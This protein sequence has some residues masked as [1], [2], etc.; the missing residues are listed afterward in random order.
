[1][2]DREPVAAANFTLSLTSSGTYS[3]VRISD[4]TLK[5][6]KGEEYK[7]EILFAIK[8]IHCDST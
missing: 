4:V 6:K 1:L 2:P 8:E 7:Q 5:K 3:F